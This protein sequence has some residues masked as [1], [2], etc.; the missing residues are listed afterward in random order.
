MD[1]VKSA[2]LVTAI[3]TLA[4]MIAGTLFTNFFLKMGR[5]L[6]FSLFCGFL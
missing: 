4:F 5:V 2:V 1:T 3:V 6:I